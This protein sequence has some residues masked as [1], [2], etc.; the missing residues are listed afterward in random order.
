MREAPIEMFSFEKLEV[1]QDAKLFFLECRKL[2]ARLNGEN[3]LVSQMQR[4][5]LS[6]VLN[7]A[8]GSG[9][10]GGKD[11]KNF[12]VIARASL[13]E[14]VAILDL[15]KDMLFLDENEFRS[16]KCKAD[17]LSRRLFVMISNLTPKETKDG[18]EGKENPE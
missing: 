7:L 3:Y 10:F 15:M 16:L 2:I 18:K 17:R 6:V 4:A 1:Y 8:E 9:K 14:S 5:T 11:R 13:F 12:I